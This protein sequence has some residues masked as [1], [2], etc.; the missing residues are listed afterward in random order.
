[1]LVKFS[2][3]TPQKLNIKDRVVSHLCPH[4]SEDNYAS[5][6]TSI[7][8]YYELNFEGLNLQYNS[9]RQNIIKIKKD[10]KKIKKSDIVKNV[11]IYNSR[12]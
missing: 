3:K 6:K 5:K 8:Q 7:Q 4:L 10:F 11:N 2:Q 9:F 1:M 12:S